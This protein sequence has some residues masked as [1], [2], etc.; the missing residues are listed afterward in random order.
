MSIELPDPDP[1]VPPVGV[2]PQ[3]LEQE[4]AGL[5]SQDR[6]NL[7]PL[8]Y[9]RL[10]DLGRHYDV[11]TEVATDEAAEKQYYEFT[12]WYAVGVIPCGVGVE[13]G[14]LFDKPQIS[15]IS[16]LVALGIGLASLPKIM[17]ESTRKR[18]DPK[19]KAASEFLTQAIQLHPGRPDNNDDQR[20]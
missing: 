5:I 16:F 18:P 11:S 20:S 19:R 1:K 4:I 14:L 7:I 3:A 17:R 15:T 10:E 8:A 9:I 2:F 13:V 12:K 6:E